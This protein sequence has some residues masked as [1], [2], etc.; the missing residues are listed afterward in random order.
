VFWQA[1]VSQ[2]PVLEHY[3]VKGETVNSK[4]NCALLTD[5]LKAIICTKRKGR[6]SQTVILQ[7]DNALPLTANK[8]LETIQDLKFVLPKHPLYS[9]DLAPRDFHML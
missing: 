8:T 7:R 1:T 3:R 6:L 5:E 4:R 2:G 9:L